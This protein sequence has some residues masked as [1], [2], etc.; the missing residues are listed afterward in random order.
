M[1]QTRQKA[2]A[3]AQGCPLASTVACTHTHTHAFKMFL[4][5]IFVFLAQRSGSC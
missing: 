5:I 2:R 3:D 4:K 1:S